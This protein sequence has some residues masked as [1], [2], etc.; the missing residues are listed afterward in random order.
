MK[1][2]DFNSANINE[3]GFMNYYFS[4][5]V[6]GNFEDIVQKTIEA[7]KKEGF[8]VLTDIDVTDTLKKSWM[9]ISKNTA[10]SGLAIHL[11]RSKHCRRKIRLEQCCLA[12]SLFRKSLIAKL[13]LL[14]SIPQCP[15]S[16]SIIRNSKKS[17]HKYKKNLRK[18]SIAFNG[19]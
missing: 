16:Q 5:T 18:L 15:C 17:H 9:W 3:R 19:N 14:Q 12:M 7:L 2:I 1:I 8:G 13:K 11:L 4:T 10:F 6:A